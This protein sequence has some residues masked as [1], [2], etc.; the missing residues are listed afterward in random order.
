MN[1]KYGRKNNLLYAY[2]QY[3]FEN[4]PEGLPLYCVLPSLM[5]EFLKKVTIKKKR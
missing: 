2:V 4:S 5:A 3:N 1:G